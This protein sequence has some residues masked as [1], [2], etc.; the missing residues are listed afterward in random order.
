[1]NQ[2]EALRTEAKRSWWRTPA[3]I[4]LV[5]FA[6]VAAFYGLRENWGYTPGALPYLLL[7]GCPL[8]RL[9]MHRGYHRHSGGSGGVPGARPGD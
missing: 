7:L 4:S 5:G 6:L 1:M 9:F 8:M 3:G 2:A